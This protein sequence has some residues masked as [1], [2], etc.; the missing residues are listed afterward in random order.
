[1]SFMLLKQTSISHTLSITQELQNQPSAPTQPQNTAPPHN[2][3]LPP[4]SGT[5]CYVDAAITPDAQRSNPRQ[6]GLGILIQGAQQTTL[7]NVF[8]QAVTDSALNPLQAETH[9]LTLASGIIKT[10]D[11]NQV[12]YL[13]D[14]KLLATNLHKQDPVVLNFLQF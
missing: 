6:A 13:T 11:I 12:Q 8:I 4:F 1:M 9:A 14:S 10:L 2:N 5:R 3:T 7:N